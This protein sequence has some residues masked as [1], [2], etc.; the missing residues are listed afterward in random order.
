MFPMQESGPEVS[1]GIVSPRPPKKSLLRGSTL[2]CTQA[3]RA[4]TEN[5]RILIGGVLAVFSFTSQGDERIQ[6]VY[7]ATYSVAFEDS[8]KNML[9]LVQMI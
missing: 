8:S 6:H 2:K 7:A 3:Y 9:Q 5:R 4:G 1:V